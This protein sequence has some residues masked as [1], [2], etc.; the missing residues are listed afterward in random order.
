M[1]KSNLNSQKFKFQIYVH[2]LQRCLWPIVAIA[3]AISVVIARPVDAV[4]R[5][6]FDARRSQL[7]MRKPI[8]YHAQRQPPQ[9]E[10]AAD[11][12]VC[13]PVFLGS[14]NDWLIF[15]VRRAIGTTT[16]TRTINTCF[17]RTDA[18]ILVIAVGLN[19]AASPATPQYTPGCCCCC[20]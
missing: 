15:F 8:V 1:K 10:L 2:Y 18:I 20:S 9:L 6:Q 11:A 4:L 16:R 3:I 19:V 13:T 5:E 14:W 7:A 17:A 12:I